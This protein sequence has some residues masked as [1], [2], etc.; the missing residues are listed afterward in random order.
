MNA[1]D[2]TIEYCPFCE[3]ESYIHSRGITPCM[4]CGKPLAPCS[5]CYE[6]I[7]VHQENGDTEYH[8][9]CEINGCPY[10]CHCDSRDEFL[11]PTMPKL[12]EEE[13]RFCDNNL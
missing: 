4:N 11:Q 1:G 8:S 9:G 6:E 10:G 13:I 2:Y 3:H 7:L 12:T 5:V